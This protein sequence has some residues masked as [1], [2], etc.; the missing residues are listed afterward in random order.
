MEAVDNWQ[1]VLDERLAVFGHRNWIVIA[2]SAYPAHASPGIE[3][4][5]TG[6][7]HLPVLAS[8]L[9]RLSQASHIKPVVYVDRELNHLQEQDAPGATRYREELALL[10][11][12]F[13][14]RLELHEAIIARLDQAAERFRVLV[15]KT[16]FTIPYTTV[17]LQL[18]C[19]YWNEEAQLRLDASLREVSSAR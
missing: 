12:P 5:V 13:H 19:A 17:F 3:T 2:D 1:K 10:L 6:T 9:Q 8:V 7:G 11:Q 14:T 15:L 4:L 16:D 18:E